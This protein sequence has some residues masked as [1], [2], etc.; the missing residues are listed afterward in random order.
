ME[1]IF[2]GVDEST[3]AQA[4]LRWAV[5][6]AVHTHQ[7]VTA[8]MAWGYIDQH[9]VEPNAPFD[10]QYSSTIAAK[11]LDDLV[12]RAIGTPEA[13][14]RLAVC[15]LPASALLTAAA[16]A[17]ML[18]VGARGMGGFRGLLLGSVSRQVL[19][20]ATCPVAVIRDDAARVGG[21]VVVG[22]D[23]SGPSQRALRWAVD[24]ARTRQLP[25]I[26]I[27]AWDLPYTATGFYLPGPDPA[28][29]TVD[30][31]RFLRD[32]VA[33]VDTTG[34]VEPV[35]C[36]AIGDRPSTALLDASSLASLVV[37]GSRGHGQITGALLGSVS[38]QVA[39]HATSPVVVIP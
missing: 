3:Y 27:H 1:G 32:Q 6:H 9:H 38:D 28:E 21:P 24:H 13:V 30:A 12:S 18:V 8:V 20:R 5:D 31:Q 23:G 17:S 14:S 4:A 11:V 29:L 10:P 33:R 35:E 2:V 25:L 26:A 15:D 37:V 7:H 36:R 16:D 19:H 34:L 39:H 22:I